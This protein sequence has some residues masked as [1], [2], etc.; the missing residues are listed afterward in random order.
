MS[1]YVGSK[2][3]S[4]LVSATEIT[5]DGAKLKSSGDSI[6]KSDGTTAVLS[7]SSGT[8]TFDADVS[9]IGSAT[10]SGGSISG[11]EINLKSSGTTIF[12]SD[13]TTAVLSESGGVVSIDGTFNGTIG[14]TASLPAGTV[15]QTEYQYVNYN[16]VPTGSATTNVGSSVTVL[17]PCTKILCQIVVTASSPFVYAAYGQYL[18]DIG[19]N[20]SISVSNTSTVGP[21]ISFV[22][23]DLNQD[24][25]QVFGTITSSKLFIRNS[26]SPP[27]YNTGDTFQP[28]ISVAAVYSGSYFYQMGI[29]IYFIK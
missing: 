27:Y 13:G 22:G 1:G 12:A 5:L 25:E 11:T 24:G 3:S 21:N 29:H 16:G 18:I 14:T 8:V 10:I 26:G 9:T 17:Y 20:A 28:Q 6:T 4:S 15:V 2:R 19:T 7:E 23:A